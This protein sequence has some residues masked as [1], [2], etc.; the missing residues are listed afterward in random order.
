MIEEDFHFVGGL[1]SYPRETLFSVFQDA[2][3]LFARHAR[4][5]FEELIDSSSRFEI[6]E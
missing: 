1:W 3:D 4:E 5:P 6:F 2:S